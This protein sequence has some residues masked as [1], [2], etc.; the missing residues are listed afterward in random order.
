MKKQGKSSPMLILFIFIFVVLIIAFVY[1]R[2]IETRGTVDVY[3]EN[4]PQQEVTPVSLKV[5]EVPIPTGFYYVGGT[6]AS[7]LIISDSVEDKEKGDNH[8]AAKVL[9]GNQFVWIPV[10]DI[11]SFKRKMSNDIDVPNMKTSILETVNANNGL[12]LWEIVIGLGKD[13]TTG[14]DK[15]I[16]SN[17]KT[18]ETLSEAQ[19]IYDSVAKYGGFYIA[20]YEAGVPT[21]RSQS[22]DP[23]TGIVSYNNISLD[24][25]SF[26][27]G[28]YPCNYVRWAGTYDLA[29]EKG[30]AI[31]LAR[32][33]YPV[34]N[35]NIGVVST[36]VYGVQWDAME[37]FCSSSGRNKYGNYIDVEYSFVGKYLMDEEKNIYTTD[38]LSTDKEKDKATLF[39]AGASSFTRINN[40]YDTA[41]SLSEWTM[42]GMTIETE[43]MV[44]Y[45]RIIRGGNYKENTTSVSYRDSKIQDYMGNDVGFRIALYIK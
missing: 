40:I 7:G 17:A 12:N 38:S 10:E 20:R 22:E 37:S 30:G 23:N 35:N 6:K 33:F 11:N 9:K 18:Q 41:G 42:E 45:A 19:A 43:D 1:M 15:L 34:S 2:Y 4:I 26:K 27:A 24:Q 36:P 29:D 8:E 13:E 32:S 39:T 25:L 3:E 14:Q 16:V 31:E 44:S 21:P 5:D 28:T